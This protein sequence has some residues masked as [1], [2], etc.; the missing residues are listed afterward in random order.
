MPR[1]PRPLGPVLASGGGGGAKARVT[2]RSVAC[3]DDPGGAPFAFFV[4]GPAGGGF[5]G[6]MSGG[7]ALSLA[8]VALPFAGAS[9]PTFA[10]AALAPLGGGALAGGAGFCFAAGVVVATPA[11]P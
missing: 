9:A 3:E 6:L 2:T 11:A 10:A 8:T 1:K 7:G 5:A 4:C